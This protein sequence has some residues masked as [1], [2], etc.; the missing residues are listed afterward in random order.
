[1]RVGHYSAIDAVH[2]AQ[3]ALYE[4]NAEVARLEQQLQHLRDSRQRVEHQ[5]ESVRSQETEHRSRQ[6]S[7]QA[8][9]SAS[10]ESW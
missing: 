7:Q 6:A 4:A 2:A 5:L 1:M 8:A 10:E 9:R 3:G